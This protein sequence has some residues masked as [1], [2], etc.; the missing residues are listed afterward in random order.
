MFEKA[1][2]VGNEQQI[3]SIKIG[4]EEIENA[5]IQGNRQHFTKAHNSSSNDDKVHS[6]LN[7]DSIRDRIMR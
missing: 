1:H 7:Q 2:K 6:K 4:K 5:I 3:I